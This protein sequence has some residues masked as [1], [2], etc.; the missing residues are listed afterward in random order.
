[1]LLVLIPILTI[2]IFSI[3]PIIFLIHSKNL[4]LRILPHNLSKTANLVSSFHQFDPILQSNFD[5]ITFWLEN[6]INATKYHLNHIT[7]SKNKN[8]SFFAGARIF[9]PVNSTIHSRFD[10]LKHDSAISKR[11]Q[12]NYPIEGDFELDYTRLVEAWKN[13]NRFSSFW[14][15]VDLRLNQ[16]TAAHLSVSTARLPRK[17]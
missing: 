16:P 2:L 4:N 13:H 8:S 7:L 15:S 3:Y 17:R 1:M 11:S 9:D 14:F 5:E 10:Y 6:H 12:F